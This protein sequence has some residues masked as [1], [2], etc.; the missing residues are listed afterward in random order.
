[1]E[2]P[3]V[4]KLLAVT[5]MGSEWVLWLMIGLSILSI[6]V[7]LE[8]A[9]FFLRSSVDFSD[10]VL[11]LAAALEAGKIDDAEKLSEK[12]AALECRV[13]LQGLRH[14]ELGPDGME[15][16]MKSYLVSQRQH[17][18][19]GLVILGTLGNNTPF[20]GLFGTVIGIINAFKD[21]AVNPAGGSAVVM[22]GISEALIATAV[23]LVVAIP[24]V[25]AFNAFQRT[26]KRRV[27]NAEAVAEILLAHS[28]QF[29]VK[30]RKAA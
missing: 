22:A 15:R 16:S 24:A 9:A 8:R 23:G 30:D 29:T 5:A 14:R 21:L 19:R 20:I 27:Q 13:A 17:L 7:M 2:S 12:A 6:G 4:H 25:I 28:A 3:L 11:E 26:V 10:Y 18:D 1:M